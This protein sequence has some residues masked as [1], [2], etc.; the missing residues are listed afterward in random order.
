MSS[1]AFEFKPNDKLGDRYVIQAKLGEGGMGTV[2]RALD[3][4]NLNRPVA[5]KLINAKANQRFAVKARQRLLRERE[6]Y[7][8]ITHPNVVQVIDSGV[9]DDG[10]LFLVQEYIAGESLDKLI[11]RK[12]QLPKN[13]I[14]SMVGQ[15]SS[16]LEAIHSEGVLHR[17]LKPTNIMLQNLSGGGKQVKIIDLGIARVEDSVIEDSLTVEGASIGTPWYSSPEQLT[18]AVA[19]PLVDLW[20]LAVIAY[21]LVTGVAPFR[22]PTIV[23]LV[24]RQLSGPI[25]PKQL[26]P[27]LPEAVS[28]V[29]MKAL[30][31][32][33]SKRY[34]TVRE[35]STALNLAFAGSSGTQTSNQPGLNPIEVVEEVEKD[36]DPTLAPANKKETEAAK[37]AQMAALRETAEK[38][39]SIAA[40]QEVAQAGDLSIR[41]ESSQPAM[42]SLGGVTPQSGLSV[43]SQIVV[44]PSQIQ[45]QVVLPTPS[46]R[47][48]RMWFFIIAVVAV[49]GV[50]AWMGRQPERPPVPPPHQGTGTNPIVTPATS[51]VS[52]SLSYSLIVDDQRG[53]PF[54]ASGREIY[55]SGDSFKF[56]V[57]TTETGYLYLLNESTSGDLVQLFPARHLNQEN[58]M[59]GGNQ[60][61]SLPQQWYQFDKSVGAERLILVFSRTPVE[62]L[63]KLQTKKL[64]SPEGI[65]TSNQSL[66]I[67]EWI[68]SNQTD[69]KQT[70]L[71]FETRLES[72]TNPLVAQITLQH[73]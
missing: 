9:T 13:E 14:L 4:R 5:I 17:D 49:I 8:R 23:L 16:A 26:R 59:V 70:N 38:P 56:V 65:I 51:S 50:A 58:S 63:E 28:T 30:S 66:Q 7:L 31:Y 41:Q 24:R 57:E 33:P 69:I 55:R 12:G 18:G 40:N 35:F 27:D 73:R 45:V 32:E 53:A 3:E 1:N 44:S 47:H 34:Q 2:Y 64:T 20:A 15:M 42:S 37:V 19:T 6:A 67:R 72:A 68:K 52:T 10:N 36:T 71:D 43:P 11:R 48:P 54:N 60:K 21:Q 22:E 39:L 25:S 29:L 46:W 61:L 62:L